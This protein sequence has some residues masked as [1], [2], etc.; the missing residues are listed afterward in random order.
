MRPEALT[1]GLRWG[2]Q[3]QRAM[4]EVFS[5]QHGPDKVVVVMDAS[6]ANSL[7]AA[8]N[9]TLFKHVAVTLNRGEQA[10]RPLIAHAICDGPRRACNMSTSSACKAYRHPLAPFLSLFKP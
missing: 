1:R 10:I 3:M 5:N 7:Q 2:A 4:T 9:V 6:G 8:R